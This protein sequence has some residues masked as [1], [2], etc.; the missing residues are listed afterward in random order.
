MNGKE[1]SIS[2]TLLLIISLCYCANAAPKRLPNAPR[3][4]EAQCS[5]RDVERFDCFPGVGASQQSCEKRGCCWTPPTRRTFVN[6]P[7]CYYPS[8]YGG[9]RYLNITN[10]RTGIEAYLTR[11]FTSPFPEDVL[12]LKMI[13][14]FEDQQRLRIKIIDAEN[15]RFES[16][17]PEIKESSG[18]PYKT[19]YK[20]II[21]KQK[22]GFQVIR[23]S[24]DTILFDA[25]DVGGF[26]YAN[27]ML[28]ISAK[29]PS[30]IIYG[31]GEHS[32][33]LLQSTNWNRIVL[34]NSDL[35]PV[36]D[37]SNFI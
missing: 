6:E 1:I 21:D 26:I 32:T 35:M 5:V 34:W 29:L 22:V 33:R 24:D 12:L 10:T 28:Q 14:K 37:V 16:P 9:Y 30:N 23:K 17:F 7:Y 3:A 27:Q 18:P 15:K 13:V 36:W 4:A 11:T 8:G 20:V 2:F 25:M 19:D 31:L